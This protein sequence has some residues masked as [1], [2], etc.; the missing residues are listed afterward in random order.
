MAGIIVQ[1][2]ENPRRIFR[3]Q[4]GIENQ[5]P[6]TV[7]IVYQLAAGAVTFSTAP[8]PAG[9][10]RSGDGM[11]LTGTETLLSSQPTFT[12]PFDLENTAGQAVITVKAS[13]TWPGGSFDVQF[14]RVLP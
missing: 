11:Q 8:V 3:L 10:T 12:H 1:F 5:P 2:Q 14:T 9:F 7:S 4:L 13:A 6:E